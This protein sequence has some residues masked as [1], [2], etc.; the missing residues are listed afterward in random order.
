MADFARGRGA[1]FLVVFQPHL[2]AKRRL[3]DG[4]RLAWDAWRT[5]HRGTHDRFVE[6]YDAMVT[7][8]RAFCEARRIAYLDLN[9]S[10]HFR[11]EA[12]ALFLDAV[13]L[14]AKGHGLVADL[15]SDRL[16]QRLR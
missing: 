2:G 6:Q 14:N 10:P 12:D 4:E 8:T 3:T 9:Q 15:V 11:D 7:R 13:H 16:R 5:A 1:D